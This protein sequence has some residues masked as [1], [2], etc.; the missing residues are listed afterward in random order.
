ML[1][2]S[3]SEA[4]VED[5]SS[6]IFSLCLA[7]SQAANYGA[8]N[9]K[10]MYCIVIMFNN[11]NDNNNNNSIVFKSPRDLYYREQDKIMNN[12]NK[13]VRHDSVCRCKGA[14]T[15]EAVY[16]NPFV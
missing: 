6:N 7:A 4:T 2:L 12:N 11:N 3:R 14:C 9:K 8:I 15:A 16:V 10:K 13:F 1:I 5:Q